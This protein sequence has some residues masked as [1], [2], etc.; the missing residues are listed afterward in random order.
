MNV[1]SQTRLCTD[2]EADLASMARAA[3]AG[4]AIDVDRFVEAVQPIVV[5][6]VRLVV[7]SGSS[8]AEEACQEALL[9]IVRGLPSLVDAERARTWAM[10][11]A[12]RRAVRAARGQRVRERFRGGDDEL[13]GVFDRAGAPERLL[14]VRE[15]FAELPVRMRTVAVLR[16]Y[17]GLSEQ[18][19][20]EA[21]GCAPGTV[22]S[23]LHSA[24]AR[25]Q[26]A[27]DPDATEGSL[28]PS[29]RPT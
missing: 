23:R 12:M 4:G 27:L 9:D 13:E 15:A 22:K 29:R 28:M 5:R 26:R 10:R 20:A 25:L 24:R 21:L 16:L 2:V 6:A 7:G 11:I 17:V 14:L 8:I 18:E 19:T 3:R 1:R